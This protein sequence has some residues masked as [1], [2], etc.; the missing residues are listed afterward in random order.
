MAALTIT[1]ANVGIGS[2]AVVAQVEAGEAVT[3]AMPV[4]Y[5]IANADYRKADADAE[6]TAQVYGISITASTGDSTYLAVIRSGSLVLGSILTQGTEYY[7]GTTA[8]EII[9][10]GD[11]ATGDYVTRLGIATSATTLKV[12]IRN[13]GVTLP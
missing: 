7:L 1:A 5:S 6:D 4:Y 11:L 9:P 2:D 8:G 10:K 13:T 3:H 12:D